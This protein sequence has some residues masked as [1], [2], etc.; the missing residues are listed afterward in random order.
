MTVAGWSGEI[1]DWP[2]EDQRRSQTAATVLVTATT[3]SSSGWKT[4]A[5]IEQFL[6]VD[7]KRRFQSLQDINPR[8]RG[9]FLDP[10]DVGPVHSHFFRKLLL[11][12]T[13]LLA[14]AVDVSSKS[15]SGQQ[16]Q[17]GRFPNLSFLKAD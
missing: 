6:P 4:S 17:F 3:L 10:L 11:R 9:S 1:I 5:G 13:S 14:E 15:G 2:T 12:Q 7:I 8:I 16:T